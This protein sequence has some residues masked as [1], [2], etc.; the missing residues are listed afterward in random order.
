MQLESG[1]ICQQVSHNR[2][3]HA[4]VLDGRRRRFYVGSETKAQCGPLPF[5]FDLEILLY[6]TFILIYYLAD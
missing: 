6:F 4:A 3:C 5:N 2:T 1:T